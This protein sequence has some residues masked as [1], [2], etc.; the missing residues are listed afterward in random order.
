LPFY[1]PSWVKNH[2]PSGDVKAFVSKVELSSPKRF[3][4]TL[5]I[6]PTS[7]DG[8]S[9]ASSHTQASVPP[10]TVVLPGY[11]AGIGF[12]YLNYPSLA[13]WVQ[14][15]RAPVYAVDWLGMGRSARVPFS[16]KA[17]RHDNVGRATEAESFFIDAL[18]EWRVKQ[19]LE[20]MT[21]IGHSLGTFPLS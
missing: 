16:V 18:E 15:W 19:G 1:L 13:T 17:K 2:T 9:S 3:L 4:N 7:S 14:R 8:D 12:F 20:Q 21:L 11:G 10:A 5:S 6:L